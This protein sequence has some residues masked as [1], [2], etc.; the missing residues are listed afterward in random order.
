MHLDMIWSH[1]KLGQ[2]FANFRRK[3]LEKWLSS[4]ISSEKKWWKNALQ[5]CVI[6]F[7]N[8]LGKNRRFLHIF[9]CTP[10]TKEF[11]AEWNIGCNFCVSLMHDNGRQRSPILGAFEKWLRVAKKY[12]NF[13]I[14][15]VLLFQSLHCQNRL[16]REHFPIFWCFYDNWKWSIGCAQKQLWKLTQKPHLSSVL[17]FV[18]LYWKDQRMRSVSLLGGKIPLSLWLKID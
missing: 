8:N 3:I 9:W 17:N 18:S 15:L 10:K 4:H 2:Q 13:I 5:V 12:E 11:R 1:L 7:L 16:L 14:Y 6:E